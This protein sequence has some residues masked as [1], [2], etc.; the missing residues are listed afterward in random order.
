ML[1]LTMTTL[2]SFGIR[3]GARLALVLLGLLAFLALRPEAAQATHLRA[4]DIK[5]TYDTTTG[6]NY[7]PRRVFSG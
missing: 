2:F 4:G 3:S 7:N 5:A 6:P 1:R